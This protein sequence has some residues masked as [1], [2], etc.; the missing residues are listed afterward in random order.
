MRKAAPVGSGTEFGEQ[1][2]HNRR[3][4]PIEGQETPA[5]GG[6]IKGNHQ[7]DREGRSGAE[8]SG[9]QSPDLAGAQMLRDHAH[10]ARSLTRS[11]GFLNRG[12]AAEVKLKIG[13]H[14]ICEGKPV[15]HC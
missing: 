8:L 5:F 10:G 3:L 6:G 12:V 14:W 4:W 7:I 11:V 1:V 13:D 2:E 9:P 15:E